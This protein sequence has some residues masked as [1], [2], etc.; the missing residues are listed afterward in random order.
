MYEEK[1][2]ELQQQVADCEARHTF[3]C[4]VCL[5]RKDVK[6]LASI[7][8]CVNHH[9]CCGCLVSWGLHQNKCPNCK[10]R[11]TMLAP[12][13]G[14]QP[15]SWQNRE[16]CLTEQFNFYERDICPTTKQ[17]LTCKK[18][19]NL[20]KIMYG[21]SYGDSIGI[22]EMSQVRGDRFAF[23]YRERNKREVSIKNVKITDSKALARFDYN[24]ARY[25]V[26]FTFLK[27][28]LNLLTMEY[29]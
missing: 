14:L 3:L 17:Q 6:H 29:E 26:R 2:R 28:E 20:L 5:E 8:S 27:N 13:L 22:F 24:D 7:N 10:Q 18:T 23:S 19:Q 1:I 4:Q 21:Q 25:E 11:F 12:A 16:D 15:E 9:F